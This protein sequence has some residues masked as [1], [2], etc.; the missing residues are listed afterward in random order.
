MNRGRV[1]MHRCVVAGVQATA[2]DT[3]QSFGRHSHD[4]FG[5]GV[6]WRGAQR[7]ASGRGPVEARAGDVITVNP[8]EVHDGKPFDE[9]GRAWCMLY[10]EPSLLCGVA[11][12]LG[13][14]RYES[15][16]FEQP[17]LQDGALAASFEQAYAAATGRAATTDD[18]LACETSLF[19]LM[20]RCVRTQTTAREQVSTRETRES[21]GS[22]SALIRRARARIDDDPCSAVSLAELAAEAG[23]SRFQFLRGFARDT[24]LPPHAYLVQRRIALA[25][26]LIA[27]GAA[28]ADAAAGAGFADQSHMTRAFVR[29]FG[30]TPAQY[31]AA[32]R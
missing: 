32:V 19:T 29:A 21:P 28:L 1:L 22:T 15:V 6:V 25:H 16:A 8:G 18:A 2:A 7:S 24:G 13:V 12:E 4:T 17:V 10:F 11:S 30:V 3:A 20:A 23:M 27:R 26:Q 31:A 14:A 9:R 5:V